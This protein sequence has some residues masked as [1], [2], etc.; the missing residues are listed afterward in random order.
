MTFMAEDIEQNR[1]K[2]EWLWSSWDVATFETVHMK[3][4]CKQFESEDVRG[5]AQFSTSKK[6]SNR[7]Y[8][9]YFFWPSTLEKFSFFR[10]FERV[11]PC[12]QLSKLFHEQ[13]F[14]MLVCSNRKY[15]VGWTCLDC[16][17]RAEEASWSV[18]KTVKN[19]WCRIAKYRIKSEKMYR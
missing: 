17:R 18:G 13:K 8:F 5:W 15:Y 9:F 10:Q 6:T 2:C 7:F 14:I 16:R 11:L 19:L 4:S 1:C 3:V 12:Y